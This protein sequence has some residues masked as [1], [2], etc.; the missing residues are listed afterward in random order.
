MLYNGGI[1]IHNPSCTRPSEMCGHNRDANPDE[2]T[3]RTRPKANP[4]CMHSQ[5]V[6]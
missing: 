2:S 5:T 3:T 1:G 4:T 6:T